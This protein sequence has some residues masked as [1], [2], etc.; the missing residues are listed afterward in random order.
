MVWVSGPIDFG[1]IE[2]GS[3]LLEEFT[4][5]IPKTVMDMSGK[6]FYSGRQAF[7]S[8]SNLYILGVNPG[9][10]PEEYPQET[11]R[12]HT[13]WVLQSSPDDWSEYRDASWGTAGAAPGTQGMQPRVLHMLRRLG[14]NPGE[15]PASNVI[16]ARSARKA[17]LK[18][19]YNQ[20]A[21]DCWAFHRAV[22]EE[23][24]VRLIVCLGSDAGNWVRRRLQAHQLVG[25][26]VEHN[27]RRWMSRVYA[28]ASGPRVAVLAHPSIADWTNEQTDPSG[29]VVDVLRD[30]A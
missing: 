3:V 22:I 8:E 15:V 29:L 27:N 20:M 28:S 13:Q 26:F 25:K 18:G 4:K 6:V 30:I 11:V 14:V 5:L 1:D 23:L 19:N 12:S 7:G 10:S 24:D 2:R 17:T 21:T 16:F 9:G